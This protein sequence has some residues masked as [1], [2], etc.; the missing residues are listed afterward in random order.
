[1][2][3]KDVS[4]VTKKIIY[5]LLISGIDVFNWKSMGTGKLVSLV[6]CSY[7]SRKTNFENN[8]DAVKGKTIKRHFLQASEKLI[9]L[10]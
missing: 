4:S 7:Q 1:M 2:V 9:F 10:I 6:I 5:I 8:M 3:E